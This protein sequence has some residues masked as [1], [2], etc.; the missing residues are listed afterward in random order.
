MLSVNKRDNVNRAEFYGQ[1]KRLLMRVDLIR[2]V[3]AA[4]IWVLRGN[5]SYNSEPA[6]PLTN[7][8]VIN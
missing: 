6:L 4:I 3:N 5:P 8:R 1:R 7:I 2:A